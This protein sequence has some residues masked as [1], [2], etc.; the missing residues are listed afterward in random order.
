MPIFACNYWNANNCY[1]VVTSYTRL[2]KHLASTPPERWNF[3][4]QLHPE[5]PCHAYA[6]IEIIRAT[7]QTEKKD[8]VDK[9]EADDYLRSREELE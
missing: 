9:T 3:F 4:E 2:W 8:V 1:Y 7:N 5:N 6:D